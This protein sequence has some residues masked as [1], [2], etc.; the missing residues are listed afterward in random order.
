MSKIT[1]CWN[2]LLGVVIGGATVI[3]TDCAL[4][5]IIFNG[6]LLNDSNS[7]LGGIEVRSN[8]FHPIP[9]IPLTP[10]SIS[11][12]VSFNNVMDALPQIIDVMSCTR[13]RRQRGSSFVVIGRG[14]LPPSPNDMLTTDAMLVD[15][16]TL[17]LSSDNRSAPRVSSKLTT[18]TRKPIV[19]ATGWVRNDKGEV[20]LTANAPTAPHSSWHNPVSCRAS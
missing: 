1:T 7:Q 18:A 13:N 20:V 6:E 17:N 15:L 8:P 3:S 10:M 14:G 4:A 12:I 2:W 19:E 5:Q 11:S 9:Q 16:I